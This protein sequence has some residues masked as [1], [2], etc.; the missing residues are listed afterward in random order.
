[1]F[2]LNDG[3]LFPP[4]K[5]AVSLALIFQELATNA[6]KHTKPSF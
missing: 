6:D 1:M 3:A 4:V 2:T 5:L